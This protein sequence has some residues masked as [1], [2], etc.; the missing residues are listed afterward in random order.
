MLLPDP[1]APP[2]LQ[3][4]PAGAPDDPEMAEADRE[5]LSATVTLRLVSLRGAS[6]T[7]SCRRDATLRSLQRELC[8]LFGKNHPFTAAS[9][10]IG[11]QAFSDGD[12][13]PFRLASNDE[14][15]SVVFGR[16]VGDPSGYDVIQRRRANRISLADECAWE[17]QVDTGETR[18]SL[19]EW[20]RVN[21]G[22][23]AAFS[24]R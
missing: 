11:N 21:R 4:P 10:C 13:V 22:K 9:V 17:Q 12:D 6:C 7:L 2:L 20:I 8:S 14:T 16:Q 18:L 24:D 5:F 3:L 15:V 1:A 19:E 23:Q